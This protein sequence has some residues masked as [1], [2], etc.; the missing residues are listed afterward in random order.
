M[1]RQ[2]DFAAP[3][4]RAPHETRGLGEIDSCVV[5]AFYLR[6]AKI[7]LTEILNLSPG[8]DV[9]T[10]GSRFQRLQLDTVSAQGEM[11][12]GRPGERAV[13][14]QSSVGFAEQEI[15]I[16]GSAEERVAHLS[17]NVTGREIERNSPVS[18]NELAVA[19]LQTADGKR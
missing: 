5:V 9:R 13:I 2:P 18:P 15:A 14:L 16:I 7:R 17:G 3:N 8:L 12:F 4:F 10:A 6:S 11:G 19:H 1:P